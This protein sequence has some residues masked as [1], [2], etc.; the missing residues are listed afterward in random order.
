[1]RRYPWKLLERG[2]FLGPLPHALPLHSLPATPGLS[3]PCA[4]R[5]VTTTASLHH[6]SCALGH[7]SGSPLMSQ[8][9]HSNAQQPHPHPTVWGFGA[10]RLRELAASQPERLHW[11]ARAVHDGAEKIHTRKEAGSRWMEVC[12]CHG[13]AWLGSRPLDEAAFSTTKGI[14]HC[15]KLEE[16]QWDVQAS[17]KPWWPGTPPLGP[18]SP[19]H[20]KKRPPNI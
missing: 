17:P 4:S 14:C 13:D 7:L 2:L 12:C 1:M 11:Y 15:V 20:Q 19:M 6:L 9:H 5:N 8:L 3:G 10:R 18:P 16:S